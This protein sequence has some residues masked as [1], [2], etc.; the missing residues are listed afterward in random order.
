MEPAASIV[1]KLGGEA[2][3]AHATGTSY[4]APYRWQHPREKG[5]TGGLIPQRH[6]RTLL[7]YARVRRIPLTAE[8]FL[9]RTEA[10]P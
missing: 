3:V 8:D 10:T 7:D 4:T 6:H 1:R 5:G 2:R 9:P